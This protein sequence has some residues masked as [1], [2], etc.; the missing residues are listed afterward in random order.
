M[1][2]K[3]LDAQESASGYTTGEDKEY[4]YN[5]ISVE[6]AGTGGMDTDSQP[7]DPFGPGDS[8]DSK[9]KIRVETSGVTVNPDP[10]TVFTSYTLGGTTLSTF[11]NG[12]LNQEVEATAVAPVITC[13]VNNDG[14]ET[15]TGGGTDSK[16]AGSLFPLGK[17]TASCTTSKTMVSGIT[18]YNQNWGGYDN[19][20]FSKIET[21]TAQVSYNI[22]KVSR[23]RP[24]KKSV[25][26][27]VKEF[28]GGWTEWQ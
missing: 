27:N 8:N 24:W 22:K 10:Q 25:S 20:L 6:P 16:N 19:M 14:N 4:A 23:T 28:T 7:I 2:I 9:I 15:E 26:T 11:I 13:T 21:V 5:C 17:V 12:A 1:G 3:A 18:T